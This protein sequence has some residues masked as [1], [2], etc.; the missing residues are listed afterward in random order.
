[1]FPPS[2]LSRGR[3]LRAACLSVICC[4]LFLV[5]SVGHQACAQT[6]QTWVNGGGTWD[7]SSLHWL[8]GLAWTNGNN[9]IFGGT[10]ET[11]T[12]AEDVSVN[13]LIFNSSGFTLSGSGL[14]G[15]AA[16]SEVAVATDGH[17]AT[18]NAVIASG[19]L[20]KTGGGTL[21][22][23]RANSF[24][25]DATINA[26]A[27]RINNGGALGSTLGTTTVAN[28]ARLELSGGI[29][30]TG[31][32]LTIN[33]AGGNN[34]GAL[35]S[36]SGANTWDG[37]II[38]GTTAA[39]I[40]GGIGS[41][42]TVTGSISDGGTGRVLAVRAAT[43]T[44]ETI[45]SGVSTYGGSTD[46]VVGVLKLSGGNDRLPVGTLLRL[47]NSANVEAA[48]F[49]L[50]G[51]NQQIGGLVDL[52]PLMQRLV[53]NT[54]LTGSTLTVN[55]VSG[56][57]L[58]AGQA[59][60]NLSLSKIGT[61]NLELSGAN[62][63][64]GTTSVSAG[65]LTLSGN[66][67]LPGAINVTG[68]LLSLGGNNAFGGAI[69]LTGGTMNLSGANSVTGSLAVNNLGILQ[70]ANSA[71][72]GSA[73]VGTIVNSGGRVEISASI[74][75]QTVTIS[76]N[77]GTDNFGA[78]RSAAS[79][80]AEWAGGVIVAAAG[81]RIGGGL[82]GTLTVS[83]VISGPGPAGVLFGR[84]DNSVT[85]LNSVNT[86]TGPT[87][88]FS[89][90]GSGTRL[91]IG[92]D[93]AI[94]ATSV[95]NTLGALATQPMRLDLNGKILALAGLDSSANHAGG[96]FLNVMSGV[97]GS[98]T[99]T[100][101]SATSY[102]YSG[103][104]TDGLGILHFV[105][106]GSGTQRL[107][108]NNTYTGTTTVRAGTLQV[109]F[110]NLAAP[111]G[112]NGRLASTNLRLEG[113]ILRLDNLGASNNSA[114]RLADAAVLTFEGGSFVHAGSDQP[115]TNSTETVGALAFARGVAPVT[116][117]YGGTNMALFTAGSMI[118]STGGGLGFLNGINLGANGSGSSSVARL[119]VT[120]PPPLVGTTGA[121]S[122]GINAAAKN[123]AIVPY[124]LGVANPA[125]GG[126]GTAGTTPNTFLTYHPD[127]GLRP[128]N[129]T[130]EFTDNAIVTGN[131]TRVT[132][133]TTV[134][135]STSINSL[136]IEGNAVPLVISSG[137]TLTV[138]SG[139]I[140][141]ASGLEPRIDGPGILNFGSREG[142][143]TINSS[144]NTFL[145]APMSGTGGITYHGSGSLVL[146]GQQNTYS[147]D[148]VLRVA[149]VIPQASSLGPAGAP[150]S[151]AFGR[152]RLI[153]D[154]STIRSTTA[155]DIIVGNELVLRADT[156][157]PGAASARNL[158]FTG[159][160]T[161][162][163]GDRAILHQSSANTIFTGVIGDAGNDLGLRVAGSGTGAVVLTGANTYTG[164]TIVEGTTLLV[165]NTT[166]SG[167][168][169]G[170]V[171]V[172]NTGTLG[173]T[174]TV[175][176]GVTSVESG[177]KLSAGVPGVSSGV[178]ILNFSG[179]LVTPVGSAW[180]VDIVQDQNG[181]ADG[182][183]AT[184]AISLNGASFLPVFS[185]V[186]TVGHVYTLASYGS[187]T[188][189]F[190]GWSEGAVISNYQINYGTRTAGT[191]TLTAVP[192]PG[193]LVLLAGALGGLFWR[194]FRLRSIT[195]K[196]S[197]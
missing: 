184:G 161:L 114:D 6:T 104:V 60:G 10:P 36:V 5:F 169:T 120:T 139:A 162:E 118:R 122:T 37:N 168:G 59:T 128:L 166:G 144:G 105:K 30:V 46:L 126:T 170:D 78:L 181:V 138:E 38:L 50:N 172:R 137:N 124:L 82:N 189:T 196:R 179:N 73:D 92:V 42:L 90:G 140:L 97:V 183:N 174:G 88:M 77:G 24:N 69:T 178:G 157:I 66:N 49:D 149:N 91:V 131:N 34:F 159:P 26:G 164:G 35:Q 47:G 61:G 16:G 132:A 146:G 173:G 89:N 4:S 116:I 148:T 185:G 192:E 28:N 119:F 145:T 14:L 110:A 9:A 156:I 127:T 43:A 86:Y 102:S 65:V 76:G 165:N 111:F 125:A 25:G 93:N 64:T 152:G 39:R 1:M 121:L 27:L 112:S 167:T 11:V 57:D 63:Y 117:S 51:Q 100:I 98:S 107:F 153:L 194:R 134:S 40:G 71:A 101:S 175:G 187:L 22:L 20:T 67:I 81:A 123:T 17:V 41:P 45:L 176:A 72:L 53:T 197:E 195:R 2:F 193:T 171:F 150:T 15:F 99:L 3:S 58:F 18:I 163:G 136:V 130:D 94:P 75:G 135:A 133:A 186:F 44:S 141:F 106:A 115:A 151:G 190:D 95:L 7:L 55:K 84:A 160:V 113:G 103:R 87:T 13:N 158:L 177:G 19:A 52:G 109:G 80:S 85:I 21:V 191:I 96:A 83:G 108:G 180:L 23:G 54:S 129:P 155:G 143:V 70:V 79:A 33:G 12:V 56:L 147:G 188:G 142:I 29:T 62:T 74:S 182:I 32:T 48:T 31:E 8:G 68:G 154:G